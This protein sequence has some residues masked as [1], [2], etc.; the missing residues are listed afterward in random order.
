[1]SLSLSFEAEHA[2]KY[3]VEEAVLIWHFRYWIELN[4]CQGRNRHEGRT[5]SYQ[6]LKVFTSLFPFWKKSAIHRI[7]ESLV[8][9]KVLVKGNFN[10]NQYDRTVW[11]AF[12]KEDL[13]IREHFKNQTS[14]N[15]FPENGKC[16]SRNPE[17][18]IP[19]SGNRNSDVGTPIPDNYPYNYQ[20]NTVRNVAKAPSEQAA[21]DISFSFE[22]G[23]F[24]D[25]KNEDLEAWRQTYLNVDVLLELKKAEEWCKSNVKKAKLKKCWRKFITNWLS[26]TDEKELNRRARGSQFLQKTQLPQNSSSM[27]EEY[28][29]ELEEASVEFHKQRTKNSRTNDDYT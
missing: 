2:V 11:Y 19:K 29:K 27:T 17:M 15:A 9:Q 3:G 21:A 22:S 1:M 26:N 4:H 8:R 12:E 13:W 10:K 28:R 14:E 25:I 5:W 7:I 18:E 23:K 24:E 16:I 20:K 6:S